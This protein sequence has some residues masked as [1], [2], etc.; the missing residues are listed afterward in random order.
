M[1][2]GELTLFYY[3]QTLDSGAV[4]LEE[5]VLALCLPLV[6][7]ISCW[8]RRSRATSLL[9]VSRMLKLAIWLTIHRAGSRTHVA[10]GQYPFV[11]Q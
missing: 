1:A 2:G 10:P 8:Y 4:N 7:C 3:F 5:E 11:P 6:V 9:L